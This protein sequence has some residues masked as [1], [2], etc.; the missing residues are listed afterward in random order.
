MM[1]YNTPAIVEE[2]EEISQHPLLNTISDVQPGEPLA[3]A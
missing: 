1:E 3:P 2:S